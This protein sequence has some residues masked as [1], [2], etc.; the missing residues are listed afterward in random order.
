MKSLPSYKQ[1]WQIAWPLMIGLIAENVVGAID[2]MFLGHV[3]ELELAASAMAGTFYI[4]LFVV[5]MGF[6]V[7]TQILVS[8]RNGEENYKPIGAIVE[9]SLYFVWLFSAITIILAF[10]FAKPV[11]S[12]VISSEAITEA[13]LRFFNI[14]VFTLFFS[15]GC[16]MMRSFFVGIQF[17]KY[18]GI[19]AFVIA[20]TNFVL[21]Y[22]MI[23]GKFGFPKMGLEGA[24]LASVLAEV[25][26][27][28]YFVIIIIRK[29]DLNKYDLF[30]FKKPQL[31]IA[32]NT[33]NLSVYTMLQ[34]LVSLISGFLFF[35]IIEKTGE[36]NLAVTN[37]VR[38]FYILIITPV[39]A[40]N[41]AVSTIVSNAIGAGQRRYV[42]PIIWRVT[43][44]G[45][46]TTILIFGLSA[47][48]PVSILRL[49]TADMSLIQIGLNGVYIVA[50]ANVVYGFTGIAFSA[51]SAT[52]NTNIAMGIELIAVAFYIV[53]IYL[54]AFN[55]AERIS[56][57]W[58]SE[59]VYYVM[60]GIGS[61]IYLST[62]HWTKKEI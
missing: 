38:S 22:V 8:R 17:T 48:F 3:G 5:G 12:F 33:F 61:F 16:V 21:D 25:A 49:Y 37:I 54:L 20:G 32:R 43:V 24:A 10:M 57:V 19:G 46:G 23:F 29:V 34:N 13:T 39:W 2:T 42:F 11:L 27:F 58:F 7:G 50:L 55:F 6:G 56:L 4:I 45:V 53:A 15:L 60:L 30:R 40:Y 26:G 9:N 41:S 52:G 59:I 18:I 31:Q 51:V 35:V 62:K 36:R 47:C 28:I 14:R 44:F 1:I